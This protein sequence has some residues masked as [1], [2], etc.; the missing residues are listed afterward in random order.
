MNEKQENIGKLKEAYSTRIEPNAG[1]YSWFRADVCLYRQEKQRVLLRLLKR[2]GFKSVSNLK[3]F[4]VGCG[5]G[6][7][8][9]NLIN[10]GAA[11]EDIYAN[12]LIQGRIDT[13]RARL[14]ETVQLFTEDASETALADGSFD[15][16][17]QS[18]VFSSIL[19]NEMQVD[20]A[21]SMLRLLRRN[22][23]IVWYD[24]LYNNPK[25]KSVRGCSKARVKELFPGTS[26]LFRRVTLAPPLCRSIVRLFPFMYPVLNVFP[27]L[28]TH[29]FA[30][31]QK[32]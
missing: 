6:D 12:D 14:P 30:L 9:L 31:I 11:P 15:L 19:S 29:T 26:I 13:A 3:I 24:F 28:R 7:N 1:N 2:A 32:R 16:I 21:N 10:L 4:E 23:C 20:L 18:T 25:N 8:I 22:G 27:F 5:F 17:F